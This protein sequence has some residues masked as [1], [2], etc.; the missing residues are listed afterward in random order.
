[1]SPKIVL[2]TFGSLGDLHPFISVALALRTRGA[3]PLLAVPHDFVEKCRAAGIEAEGCV[4]SFADVAR[5]IGLHDKR[6]TRKA[7]K[8]TEFMIR[9]SVLPS[10][11]TSTELLDRIASDAHAIVGSTFALAAP[12]VAEK[13]G[14]P[15]VSGVLQ[16]M[17]WFSP[18]DPPLTPDFKLYA[19][20]PLG[21]FK[22]E[23]NQFV[24]RFLGLVTRLQYGRHID[25]VR[26][27]QGLPKSGAAPILE[28]G[29]KPA[30]SLGLY[31]PVL[32]SL[33]ADTPQSARLTG[34]PWF[35]SEDGAAPK[36][37]AELA[38]FLDSGPAP[39]VISLG[40]VVPIA[41][42]EFYQRSVAIA[43]ELGLRAVLLT[44]ET[45]PA[46][47]PDII[48]R[49]YAPHSLLFPR[50]AAIVHHGGIGT[51]GQALRAGV[52]QLVIPF[53]ADQFDNA[54]RIVRMGVGLLTSQ[55]RYK[56]EGIKL[57]RRLL[58]E[59]EFALTAAGIG[60][61]VREEDGAGVAADAIMRIVTSALHT[62]AA[63][64]ESPAF[65]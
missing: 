31:S 4:P 45:M 5:T 17:G 21:P 1:M 27:A 47:S 57:L 13:Y 65:G 46:S 24:A 53:M 61:R 6:A 7:I 9:K 59:Q 15:F 36:L 44:A 25:K 23:W 42:S 8:S 10:L 16:P 43:C 20:P 48:V 34:F 55:R 49:S 19:K 28:P 26:R 12:I 33:P 18:L 14:I 38:A 39:L 51:T 32:R 60:Q 50:A 37:D 58:D 56:S 3:S 35:D 2:A 52:P 40:T 22:A 29:T 62:R 30:V 64:T 63:V 54:A 11:A 41:A